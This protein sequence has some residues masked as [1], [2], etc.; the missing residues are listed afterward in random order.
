MSDNDGREPAAY[1]PELIFKG[2]GN[3]VVQIIEE[4]TGDV[5]YTTRVR[6]S[7]YRPKVYAKGKYTIRVGEDLPILKTVQGVQSVA[8]NSKKKLTIKVK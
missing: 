2:I 7:N 4:S 3:P 6:G 5:L 8:A 1:L